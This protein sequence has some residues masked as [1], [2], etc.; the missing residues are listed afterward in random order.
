MTKRNVT[1]KFAS[2][3][4]Y[5]RIVSKQSGKAIDVC[6]A[7]MESGI[8]LEVNDKNNSDSQLWMIIP[9]QKSTCRFRNKATNKFFD[10]IEGGTK[11][12]C[13]LHQWEEANA[14]TQLWKI[15]STGTAGAYKIKSVAAEKYLDIVGISS[16]AGANLQLWENTDGDNQEWALELMEDFTSKKEKKAKMAAPKAKSTTSKPKKITPKKAVEKSE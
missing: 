1:A 4:K 7:A 10:V 14:S 15:E 13:W 3:T 16:I 11:N 12:G 6:D 5:Y 9:G 2:Q 8:L